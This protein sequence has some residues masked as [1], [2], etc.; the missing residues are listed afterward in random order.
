MKTSIRTHTD[1]ACRIAVELIAKKMENQYFSSRQDITVSSE[2]IPRASS[3]V[4]P[5]HPRR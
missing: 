4:A 1:D 3:G 2:F 5:T